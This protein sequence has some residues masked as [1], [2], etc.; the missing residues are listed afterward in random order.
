MTMKTFKELSIG[1]EFF[2]THSK[3]NTHPHSKLTLTTA[4]TV[5]GATFQ[6]RE[7]THVYTAARVELQD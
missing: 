1:E 5:F 2:T 3:D 4:R 6:V 7:N